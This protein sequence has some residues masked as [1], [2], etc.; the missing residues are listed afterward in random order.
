MTAARR[1]HFGGILVVGA[2]LAA[3]VVALSA[4][5]SATAQSGGNNNDRGGSGDRSGDTFIARRCGRRLASEPRRIQ[6]NCRGG[7]KIRIRSI[8]W[9]SFEDPPARGRG[10]A[11]IQGVGGRERVKLEA[12]RLSGRGRLGGRGDRRV[13]TYRRL[14]VRFVGNPPEGFDKQFSERLG[15]GNTD[16]RDRRGRRNRN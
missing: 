3:I 6:I 13:D 15:R 12:K 9:R 4:A 10:R 7:R 16:R 5:G 11:D 1:I 2:V 14:V 8:N